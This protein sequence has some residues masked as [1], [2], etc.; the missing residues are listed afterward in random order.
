MKTKIIKNILI[1]G[2]SVFYMGFTMGVP[3]LVNLANAEGVPE[4]PSEETAPYY[5]QTFITTA[6]YS[7]LQGQNHYVTGSYEGDIYLNGNGTNGADGTEVYP[8][9]VAAPKT[10]AFGTKMYIPGIGLVAVH[11][12]GGAIKSAGER[13]NAYD[14]LD[15]WMGSGDEGLSRALSWGKRTIDIRV[16]GVS[17][18]LVEDVYFEEFYQV[19]NAINST[20]LSPLEFPSDI[21]FGSSGEEVVKMQ[22]YLKDWGYLKGEVDGFY[23]S[24]TAQ[25]IFEFQ[26]DFNIV[27]GPDE[28][29]AGHFGINTRKKFDA[30]IK[31]GDGSN[32]IIETQKGSAL[33]SKYSDLYEE[34]ELFGTALKLGDSGN[35]VRKLQ[36]ELVKLGYLRISPTGYFG[37]TTE[38]ALFKYQQSI[39]LVASKD[40]AGAGYLGPNTRDA[41]NKI[42]ENR[43]DTKISL[44]LGR[45]DISTGKRI[46]ELPDSVLA[47]LKKEED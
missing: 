27:Y 17:P 43:Y 16:Y 41:L 24:D 15:I 31:G 5:V 2:F 12:R 35:T 13:G 47:S 37:E 28:L 8:G 33:M 1:T 44:A 25:A 3:V 29:G 18:S 26:M 4:A 42:L 7:P 38:H 9:M 20:I 14:R 23:G 32:E 22:Q 39:G 46:V 10:Y 11:D 19:S 45:E 36:E 21:Y 6:Y 34:K 30:S 40:D